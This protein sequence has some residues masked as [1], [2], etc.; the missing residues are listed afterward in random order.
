MQAGSLSKMMRVQGS[1]LHMYVLYI[2][3]YIY[4]LRTPMDFFFM[5]R[6]YKTNDQ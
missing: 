2:S 4:C 1:L 5:L 3:T 6:S